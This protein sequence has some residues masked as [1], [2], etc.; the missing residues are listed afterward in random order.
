MIL[1]HAEAPMPLHGSFLLLLAAQH[2]WPAAL[3]IFV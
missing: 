1:A 3:L 2:R